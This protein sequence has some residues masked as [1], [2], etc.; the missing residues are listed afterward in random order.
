MKFQ[1]KLKKN[2]TLLSLEE[3][4]DIPIVH[5][6][7]QCWGTFIVGKIYKDSLVSPT[8]VLT[9]GLMVSEVIYRMQFQYSVYILY[10]QQKHMT[11]H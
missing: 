9:E 4:S 3:S 11:E 7:S 6:K 10:L 2:V 1:N 8:S 5:S